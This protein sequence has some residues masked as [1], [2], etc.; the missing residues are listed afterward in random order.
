MS[1]LGWRYRT[2]RQPLGNGE[3][4][5]QGSLESLQPV[6][7]AKRQK[8][9]RDDAPTLPEPEWWA[10]VSNL[11]RLEGGNEAVHTLSAPYPRYSARETEQKIQHVLEAPGPHTC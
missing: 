11:A 5:T 3:W 10:M 7:T 9:C 6:V 8:H 1:M 2:K 4:R